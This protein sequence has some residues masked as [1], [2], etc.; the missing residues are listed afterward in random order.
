LLANRVR[1]GAG[2]EVARVINRIQDSVVHM[3]R[4][5]TGIRGL[6]GFEVHR[7]SR[8]TGFGGSRGFEVHRVSRF[9]HPQG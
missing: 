8:F 6:Q 5:F 1:F 7:D 4:R 2:S 9:T 3:V